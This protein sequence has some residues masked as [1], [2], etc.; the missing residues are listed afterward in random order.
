MRDNTNKK[1]CINIPEEIKYSSNS[2]I[3]GIQEKCI[4]VPHTI[5]LETEKNLCYHYV[6]VQYNL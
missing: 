4:K 3:G 5:E 1:L 6:R 2:T